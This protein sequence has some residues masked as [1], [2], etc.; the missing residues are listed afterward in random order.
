MSSPSQRGE[1]NNFEFFRAKQSLSYLSLLVCL[2]ATPQLFGKID[3]I[4]PIGL[5]PGG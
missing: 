2:A 4:F 1:E 5:P 3:L